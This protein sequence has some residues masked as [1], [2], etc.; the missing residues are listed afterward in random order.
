MKKNMYHSVLLFLSFI[1]FSS[2][3]I[4]KDNFLIEANITGLP[5][6]SKVILYETDTQ[7]LV[8]SATVRDNT[9]VLTGFSNTEPKSY[10]LQ[11]MNDKINQFTFM[12]FSNEEIKING[13]IS[14][15]PNNLTIEGSE[16]NSV[17]SKLDKLTQPYK[18]KKFDAEQ[19][20]RK[21]YE[22]GKWNDSIKNIYLG[23]GGV[24]EQISQEERA[25]EKQFI[26][27]N[28]NT[29]YCLYLMYLYKAH[30]Y[31]DSE[32][33]DVYS[34]LS[35]K[36]KKNKYA[37]AIKV[38]LNTVKPAA[39]DKFTN[40]KALN[41]DGKLEK[42]SKYFDG[43]YVLLDF[44]SPTCSNSKNALPMLNDFYNNKADK[45][46]IISYYTGNNKEHFEIF[47]NKEERPWDFI[48]NTDGEF[49]EAYLKYY[50]AGT[51]TYYLFDPNGVLLDTW[52]GYTEETQNRI[53]QI[54]K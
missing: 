9:F 36:M 51:P 14:D 12:Y 29:Y 13:N 24:L 31:T 17:K 53:E 1:A 5:D 25:V 15:L 18:T 44:S 7:K 49:N 11:V 28:S 52:M 50:V 43:K 16:H 2:F 4:L 22:E 26:K 32:L 54:V 30:S 33:K 38:Q 10:V 42:F 21:I 47:S 23:A 8:D 34:S 20:M 48:W 39:G 19:E 41:R 37:E 40:F 45:I 35:S 3:S 46:K 6:G 27:E